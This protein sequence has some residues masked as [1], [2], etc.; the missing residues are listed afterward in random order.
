MLCAMPALRA[1]RRAAPA[2]H[3]TLVGLPGAASIV[4]RFHGELD[5]LLPFPGLPGMPEQAP[6]ADGWGEFTRRARAARFDL[7][8]QLHGDGRIT[9]RVLPALA[10]RRTAGFVPQG[11]SPP[12]PDFLA[13]P[14]ELPEVLRYTALMEHLGIA[15]AD[16]GLHIPLEPE[17]TAECDALL[18]TCGLTP[19]RTVLLHPGARLAS[20]RWAPARFAAVGRRLAR[21]GYQL[22]I[23]GS[24]DEALITGELKHRLGVPAH[25]LTGRTSL[26]G[27]AALVQRCAL[28][29]CNDTGMSHVAAAM[30]T[31][32]VV[33]AS[34]SD[35]HRWAPL[36]RQR[37]RVLWHDLPCRPC[38]HAACP[39]PGHPCA[40]AVD[41]GT[42]AHA[43]LLQLGHGERR[44]A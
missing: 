29:V 15:V 19:S 20:R 11:T 25:D 22:A 37:H 26:G 38:A 24:P 10:A 35:V 17:D 41:P 40:S 9:N 2:A 7:A 13:W 27:L 43:A 8:I 32:S 23:T 34:G 30:R 3:I 6:D 12:S 5:A 1:L 42:V 33:I 39:Y 21:A 44:H 14:D 4:Q 18:E 28:V 16:T 31:P 36:D